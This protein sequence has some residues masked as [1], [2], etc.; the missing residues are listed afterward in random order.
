[1]GN[2]IHLFCA[3]VKVLSTFVFLVLTLSRIV[4]YVGFIK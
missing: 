4:C 2:A 1:M 3:Y